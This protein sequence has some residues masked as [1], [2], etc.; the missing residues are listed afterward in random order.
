M[1]FDDLVRELSIPNSPE[2]GWLLACAFMYCGLEENAR[3]LFSTTLMNRL[4]VDKL[5]SILSKIDFDHSEARI[6]QRALKET[7]NIVTYDFLSNNTGVHKTN[8]DYDEIAVNATEMDSKLF[9]SSSRVAADLLKV[10]LEQ[11]G[12]PV[13]G[14]KTIN[15]HCHSLFF[16][17][18]VRDKKII[19]KLSLLK[20]NTK[21]V[22][23]TLKSVWIIIMCNRKIWNSKTGSGH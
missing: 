6:L 16:L 9:I 21:L 3:A 17:T 10:L 23:M 19:S 1:Y 22:L 18:V 20:F 8:T 4:E 15:R 5:L 12:P 13:V 2:E 11:D 14:S 7:L